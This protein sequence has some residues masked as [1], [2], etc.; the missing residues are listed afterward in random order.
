MSF[1]TILFTILIKP[2]YLVFE[3]IYNIT[4]R[5]INHPGLSIIVLSFIMNILVLP[6]YRRADAMQE[7]ERDTSERL[8]KGIAH[9]KKTFSG[10]ERMMILQTYYRQNH[11]K[12]TDALNGSV[13]LL[14]EI[15]FFIAAY[16]FLSHL[17]I[18]EG[19]SL[20]PIADL[21]KPDA[22]LTLGGISIN[23]L[24]IVMTLVNVISSAIYLK[25]FPLKTKIQLYGMAGFFLIFLYTSPS[26]LVFY[27]TLNNLFSLA[28]TCCYKI[29][30]PR[31]YITIIAAVLGVGVIGFGL[32]GYNTSELKMKIFVLTVGVVLLLPMVLYFFRDKIKFKNTAN[33][34][35][36]RSSFVLAGLFISVLVGLL[37]PST[38][39]GASPQEFVDTSYFHNPMLYLVS[40]FCLAFG[41]FVVWMNVFYWLA[42]DAG[43]HIFERGLWILCGV[44]TVNYMFFGTNLGVISSS[45]QYENCLRFTMREQL[46]NLVIILLL[47]LVLSVVYKILKM[48]IKA[49][50]VTL[51]IALLAMSGFNMYTIQNSVKQIKVEDISE[52]PEFNLSKTGKNVVVLMLDRAMGEYIPYI[53]NEKPELKERFDGFT[54]YSNVVSF[55]AHTNFAAPALFGG[56]EYTP[57]EMNK[58]DD[59]ILAQK[60]N[61]AISLMPVLYSENDYEVTVCDVPYANYSWIPD[62]SIYDEYE[63]V[64]AYI[65][66]GKFS[67]VESKQS[68][69]DNNHRNFFV[70]SV[71]KTMPLCIQETIYN[72]GKYNQDEVSA[73]GNQIIYSNTT[74]RGISESFM[75][76]YSVL[77]NLPEMTNIK[78]DS[79]NTFLMMVNNTTHE[80]DLLQM[81]DYVP[82]DKVDNSEY[83]NPNSYV[84]DNRKLLMENDA[85]IIPYHAH[86]ATMLKLGEWFD[87]MRENNVYDN[88]RIII[89][90]D[91][92]RAFFN[93]DELELDES[94][95]G[96]KYV[97]SYFPLLFV[98]DFQ[99]TGYTESDEFM[100]NA[101]VPTLA[102]KDLINNPINPFTGNPVNS[103]AKMN[104][105]QYVTMSSEWGVEKNNGYSFLPSQ[106][107]AVKDDI[108]NKDNWEIIEEES[109]I[110]KG[111]E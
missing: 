32:L 97:G 25:G 18:L 38:L 79:D 2:L 64:K 55:G 111:A 63:N 9:I 17:P 73:M 41:C 37:I 110:P 34:K 52:M 7:Q 16:Q 61:E 81:P 26:G 76:S 107:L 8:S 101:D 83:F 103:E 33:V 20:G 24:P 89:V 94:G 68:V 100:T 88:T 49:V 59:L 5:T 4:N 87:Y 29:K 39:I 60:H 91:H 90:A 51:T 13:S 93:I 28:K 15:P 85:Q 31:K 40:S 44:M 82:L 72:S 56:Y 21:A 36:S 109:V 58:R 95:D 75:R 70:F 22:L 99:S 98:K 71:M 50:I 54:Y 62:M 84:V 10:D 23:I 11:Y 12:P 3:I 74:A 45:L 106:W 47:A 102:M 35:N 43:K 19:V 53:M 46:I 69:I 80:P 108:W 104:G 30:N 65:T 77:D 14:L 105:V 27:W 42:N 78:E 96:Y 66:E 92:G 1:G 6:L 86:M 48:K 57:L 67:G